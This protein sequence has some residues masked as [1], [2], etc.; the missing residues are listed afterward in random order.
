MALLQISEPGQSPA[1]H[2]YKRAAGIDL[3]TTNSL[4]ATVQNGRPAEVIAD[5]KGRLLLPS[6]VSF[7]E[8]AAIL[9]EEALVGERNQNQETIASFKRWIGK[10]DEE[11]NKLSV[12]ASAEILKSLAGRAE[13]KLGGDL[14]GVVITVPAY[15]DDAQRQATKDAAE[16]A[17]VKVLRL[18]NEPTAAALAYGLDR[19]EG[20]YVAVYDLGGGT[21]DVSIMQ[22]SEG[23]FEVLATGGDVS[24]GGD[25]F[26]FALVQWLCEQ[27]SI[28]QPI[29]PS[30]KRK[31]K[32]KAEQIKKDLAIQETVKVFIEE[33]AWQGI[34]SRPQFNELIKPFVEKTLISCR[35]CLQDA[36]LDV[37]DIDELVF[38]GGSTRTP[39]VRELVEQFFDNEAKKD[40][41]PD[42]VVAIGAAIQADKLV[43]NTQAKDLL[44]LDVI[45]LSLGI[46]TM[47]GLVEKIVP[48]N[49]AIPAA[50]KQEFTTYK[51]G[52]TAM[53]IH[54]LQGE[55]ERV[56]DCRSLAKFELRDI[57]PMVAGAAKIGITFSV[58]ADG[59]LSVSAEE[60]TTNTIASITV[61][62]SSGLSEGD[63]A[64]M[65]EDSYRFAEEDRDARMLSES[66]VDAQQL[67]ELIETAISEDGDLLDVEELKDIDEDIAALRTA[68]ESQDANLIKSKTTALGGSSEN[69]A[70]KRMNRSIEK[71]LKG[72]AVSEVAE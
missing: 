23:V 54:V 47:G 34:V 31:L 38:V 32:L 16:I 57:P 49:T 55:R 2:Q 14:E 18:I 48:R 35:R 46:E 9:G 24:L 3:G 27:A 63:I 59:M 20:Q 12:K 5:A 50:R 62:P 41:N 43:G 29:E 25:D 42:Q 67:L 19:A 37:E 65:L 17:G 28:E 4:V 36:D 56:E 69:F 64:S 53:S 30:L 68:L 66:R 58:D 26:D 1:P 33:I 39:L 13:S 61:Q 52:Q 44:L 45:P 71:A 11:K 6:V 60:T 10:G 72:K 51:D 8:D 15:F 70:A 22:L 40:V 7:V 21:F